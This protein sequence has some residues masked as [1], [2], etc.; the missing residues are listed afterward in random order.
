MHVPILLQKILGHET[1]KGLSISSCNNFIIQM[2]SVKTVYI[3]AWIYT[4]MYMCSIIL[5]PV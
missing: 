5:M 1:P 2:Q 4:H 3:V